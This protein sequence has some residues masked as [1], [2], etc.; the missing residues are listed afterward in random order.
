MELAALGSED[1][2]EDFVVLETKGLDTRHERLE[3]EGEGVAQREHDDRDN[4]VE[5]AT[6]VPVQTN[7]LSAAWV[8]PKA[9][10]RAK[11]TVLVPRRKRPSKSSTPASSAPDARPPASANRPTKPRAR[12][13]VASAVPE[14]TIDVRCQYQPEPTTASPR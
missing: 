9:A 1:A 7:E 10:R 6:A 13:R 5:H 11:E 14:R 3:G 8:R 2:R 4:D 12:A